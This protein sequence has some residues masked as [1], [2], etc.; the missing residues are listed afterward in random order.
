M[1][2]IDALK[3]DFSFDIDSFKKSPAVSGAL[4]A[5]RQAQTIIVMEPG[6]VPGAPDMGVGI[7]LYSF[8]FGDSTTISEIREKISYQISRFLDA[9][10]AETID[11]GLLPSPAGSRSKLLG[12]RMQFPGDQGIPATTALLAFARVPGKS[13][14]VSDV[15]VV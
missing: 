11:V 4:A 12:V 14:I 2:T 10:V 3:A 5:A 15:L 8:E 6:T 13:G 1:A 9:G 7:G